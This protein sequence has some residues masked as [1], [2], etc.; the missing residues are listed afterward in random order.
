MLASE[1]Q[2]AQDRASN[3]VAKDEL[4]KTLYR[5]QCGEYEGMYNGEDIDQDGP[6]NL[7]RLVIA[8]WVKSSNDVEIWM[9]VCKPSLCICSRSWACYLNQE[10][11]L[12]PQQFLRIMVSRGR[13]LAK[14]RDISFQG[15]QFMKENDNISTRAVE[16]W[17]KEKEQLR[18]IRH[19]PRK[20]HVNPSF[21]SLPADCRL[22]KCEKQD[23]SIPSMAARCGADRV[24]LS[25]RSDNPQCQDKL[26]QNK[27]K[28]PTQ[29][30]A[31]RAFECTYSV[32]RVTGCFCR[33]YLSV[34]CSALT[35]L[36]NARAA[37]VEV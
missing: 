6:R 7:I 34:R 25:I 4:K 17:E 18:V 9:C 20:S 28:R 1:S 15:R 16:K 24:I 21:H 8:V 31:S 3:S 32:I 27:N 29:Y 35:G 5:L 13:E 30:S 14:T 12:K 36:Q 33:L 37:R 19:R 11:L 2:R 22:V 26:D 23:K 10:A